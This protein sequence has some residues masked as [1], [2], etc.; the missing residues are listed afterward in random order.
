MGGRRLRRAGFIARFGWL[1]VPALM[2]TAPHAAAR[3]IHDPADAAFAG[4]VHV[5]MPPAGLPAD[6][7]EYEFVVAGVT[8]RLES[9]SG[10]PLL[11]APFTGQTGIYVETF[12]DSGQG[13]V[14][15]VS[16]PVTAIGFLGSN[17]D[18]CPGAEFVGALDTELVHT[19][20]FTFCEDVFI[21]AADI[22]D[23][24][25]VNIR[26]RGS[27]FVVH[28]LR[29][30]PSPGSSGQADL[31]ISVESDAERLLPDTA[32][33]FDLLLDNLGPDDGSGVKIID[34][35]PTGLLSGSAPPDGV[36]DVTAEV[37]TWDR[38]T[39]AAGS[40][41]PFRIDI[42]TPSRPAFGCKSLLTNIAAV[43]GTSVDPLLANNV[44]V[45]TIGFDVQAVFGEPEICGNRI[46][47][48]CDG[49][50]DCMDSDC[51]CPPPRLPLD[52][53]APAPNCPLGGNI[54]EGPSGEVI[55][56]SGGCEPLPASEHQCQ[57]PRGACGGVV[58]PAYCCDL[59]TWSDPS[60]NASQALEACRVEVPGCAPVDPNFKESNPTVNAA[61][62][63]YAQAGQRISYRIHYENIGN[64][65]ALNVQVIDVLDSSLDDAT[66]IVHDGGR[67]D[68]ARR[69]L[70][71][72]DPS[73]PPGEPRSV[74]FEVNVRAD[75]APGNRVRNVASI[76]FPNAEPPSR[77]DTAPIEHVLIDP[78][79]PP[80]P[81]L[82]V[83]GCDAVAPGIWQVRLR[84]DGYGYAYN[85][86]ASVV[87]PPA[88]VVVTDPT[89][90][91]AH[92][93]DE[94]PDALATVI[95][96][97]VTSSHDHIAFTTATP[98]DPCPALTWRIRWENLQGE[99]SIREVQSAADGDR[100]A[101][102]DDVDNCPA[103]ANPD[104]QDTDRDGT[105]DAC[106]APAE[107]LRCDI[108]L[109]GD[110]DRDDTAA[111]TA[112]RNT[113]ANGLDD[114]RDAD[115]DGT[116]TVLDARQCVLECTRP[117]C[118]R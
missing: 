51:H 10:Q 102:P 24:G 14:L 49:Q 12:S 81:E 108:D 33:G 29:F 63:G 86:A 116:I 31:A 101:V 97:A 46:D 78:Q 104:Q 62:Y 117:G 8:F 98:G 79:F 88:G 105:G 6:A 111:I 87:D 85:V 68:P 59:A 83:V 80:S 34:F 100:D 2:L 73:L 50:S 70:I 72:T 112:A 114:P 30:V 60:L 77:I 82:S 20:P 54:I 18:G 40:G 118:A 43:S 45:D 35:P 19:P 22:G 21:G 66:L 42:L 107:P 28:D 84:N 75:A 26:R 5:P 94:R 76:V 7:L 37:V 15:T 61:G 11:A 67:Y 44:A 53:S 13:V 48:D 39:V 71:W 3:G 1:A 58:L 65:D 25:L 89:A 41:E 74:G 99:E 16:P 9:T 27:L 4:A 69:V 52:P 93:E 38:A 17:F 106:E 47:D 57:V 90:R 95:P 56:V 115:G 64:A 96:I 91:F 23:I 109:D 113:P 55:V 36:V 103:V 110:V 32:G 92:D